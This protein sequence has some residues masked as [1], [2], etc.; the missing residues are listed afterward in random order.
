[1]QFLLRYASRIA[2]MKVTVFCNVTVSNL[3]EIIGL[4]VV[5]SAA[6]IKLLIL[7]NTNRIKFMTKRVLEA[8]KVSRKRCKYIFD[9]K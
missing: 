7:H 1:M 5:V 2:K 8:N 6:V 4:S 9:I 3:A